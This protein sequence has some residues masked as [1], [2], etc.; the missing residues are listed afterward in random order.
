MKK[1]LILLCIAC[2]AVPSSA[3]ITFDNDIPFLGAGHMFPISFSARGHMLV[4]TDFQNE[5]IKL[6]NLNVNLIK[7]INVVP[8]IGYHISWISKI[9]DQLFNSDTLIEFLV[10]YQNDTAGSKYI[11]E[12]QNENGVIV[13]TFQG[14][15]FGEQ[16]L[17]WGN[18]TYKL[19]LFNPDSAKYSIYSLPG[20]LP[21]DSC[22]NSR[23]GFKP[24]KGSNKNTNIVV[25]S[26]TPNPANGD[27]AITYALPADI[28][29][30]YLV[31]TNVEGKTIK[32]IPLSNQQNQI[33]VNMS[34]VSNGMYYF[35]IQAPSSRSDTKKLVFVR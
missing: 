10:R 3:Q 32:K 16:L 26:P 33:N 11:A 12:V 7:T 18:G 24:S 29:T 8:K 1:I 25:G 21:C 9:T 2:M 6:Y 14:N 19:S 15:I 28:E 20:S 4:V 13:K 35:Y 5:K 34:G 23:T 30:A 27:V 17:S 22:S 31:L